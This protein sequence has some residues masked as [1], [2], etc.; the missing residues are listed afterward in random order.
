[1]TK[2]DL[3]FEPGSG[4]IFVGHE[5]IIEEKKLEIILKLLS[6][7]GSFKSETHCFSSKRGLRNYLKPDFITTILLMV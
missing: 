6:N 3:V 2:W 7:V 4:V 5:N 1:M